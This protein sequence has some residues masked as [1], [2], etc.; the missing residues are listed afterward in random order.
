M[1]VVWFALAGF[2]Y[3]RWVA[4]APD[5]FLIQRAIFVLG[6]VILI[7]IYYLLMPRINY[8]ISDDEKISI[9]KSSVIIRQKIKRA[10]LECC[11]V[12]D[13]D[14]EFHLKNGK[15]YAIHLDWCDKEQVISFIRK[16]QANVNVYEGET[17]TNI[18]LSNIETL[19]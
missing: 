10:D 16:L 15:S 17:H 7:G 8:I 19:K 9:H 6:L 3:I 5:E 2:V 4:N 13:R 11:R 1:A 14:L 18:N 12:K